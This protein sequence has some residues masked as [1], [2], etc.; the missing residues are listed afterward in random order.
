[1]NDLDRKA[2]EILKKHGLTW[3]AQP[4][5]KVDPRQIAFEQRIISIP[6]G[7]QNRQT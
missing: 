7:G 5:E 6:A 3:A 4:R 2:T 1:M